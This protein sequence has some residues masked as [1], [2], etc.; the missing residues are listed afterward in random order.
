MKDI[1]TVISE[2]LTQLRKEKKL[3]Q[4]ELAEKF[5]YSDKAVSKWENGDTLPDV[6]TL[7]QLCDFY[8]VTLD[9]LTHE[10]TR[11]EK[12]QFVTDSTELHNNIAI[13]SLIASAVWMLATIIYVYGMIA[14]KISYWPAFVIGC[15]I[16]CL[17]FLVCNRIFFKSRRITFICSSVF[18]WTAIAAVYVVLCERDSSRWS[19]LWPLFLID[20]PLQAS[21]VIWFEMKFR[22]KK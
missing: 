10:G 15:P 2:N 11:K 4:L 19:T 8:G 22:R 3:T 18:I 1:R 12:T 5:N 14:L 20:V 13:S 21:L 7:Q 16:S 17:T 6:E 9:Y